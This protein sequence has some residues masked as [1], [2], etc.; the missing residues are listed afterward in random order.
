MDFNLSEKTKEKRKQVQTFIKDHIEPMEN[1][2]YK[3][4][5]GRR[6]RQR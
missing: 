2:Y 4:T 6:A 1:D 5:P 3:E